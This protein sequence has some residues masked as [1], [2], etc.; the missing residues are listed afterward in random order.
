MG[1]IG[2]LPSG[3]LVVMPLMKLKVVLFG[4]L[5]FCP[6]HKET[7]AVAEAAVATDLLMVILDTISA[8]SLSSPLGFFS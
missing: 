3:N 1:Q 7:A 6:P 4:K 2:C 8:T 5:V